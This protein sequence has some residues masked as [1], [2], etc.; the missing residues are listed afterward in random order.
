MSP[1]M[2][3]VMSPIP[4]GLKQGLALGALSLL[5]SAA[6]FSGSPVQPPS[7][8][9]ALP[10]TSSQQ[11]SASSHFVVPRGFPVKV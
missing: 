1:L 9:S 4:P 10:F 5:V 7:T 6:G 2:A 8:A 3:A 11:L